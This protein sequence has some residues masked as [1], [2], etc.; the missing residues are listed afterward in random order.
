MVLASGQ[1]QG[2]ESRRRGFKNLLLPYLYARR[3]KRRTM[4]FKTALFHFSFEEK[5][6]YLG[7]TQ[8]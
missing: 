2:R 4:S 5:E 6:M 1:I 7:I 8:K 3:G